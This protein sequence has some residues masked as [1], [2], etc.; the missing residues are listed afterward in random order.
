MI[1]S[2]IFHLGRISRGIF[3]HGLFEFFS[4]LCYLLIWTEI[5]FDTCSWWLGTQGQRTDKAELILINSGQ[6]KTG[7]R[8]RN[9]A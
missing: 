1:I 2:G 7:E 3:S 4:I 6:D 9:G 5:A 8:G